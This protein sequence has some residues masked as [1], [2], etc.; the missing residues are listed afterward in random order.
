MKHQHRTRCCVAVGVIALGISGACQGRDVRIGQ[1]PTAPDDDTPGAGQNDQR[2][3]PK[4]GLDA[5]DAPASQSDVAQPR[6]IDLAVGV[7][8]VCALDAAG[9]IR[10]RGE[11]AISPPEGDYEYRQLTAGRGFAC[12]LDAQGRPTCW[13]ANSG[14]RAIGRSG[15]LFK[16]LSAGGHACGVLDGGQVY[17]RTS[18]MFGDEGAD[19][20]AKAPHGKFVQVSAGAAH[21][22]GVLRDGR[23]KCWGRNWDGVARAPSGKFKMVSAGGFISC[24]VRLSGELSC[25]GPK[26]ARVVPKGKFQSVSAGLWHACGLRQDGTATCWGPKNLNVGS[27][28]IKHLDTPTGRFTRLSSGPK[29]ACALTAEGRITCWGEALHGKWADL[30][31]GARP[32]CGRWTTWV[33]LGDANP[34]SWS[35]SSKEFCEKQRRDWIAAGAEEATPCRCSDDQ[36][37]AWFQ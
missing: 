26:W 32:G 31:E 25:W 9:R 23:A 15:K 24:G 20:E 14:S 34:S 2:V 19:G 5:A 12:A 1:R 6:F 3:K 17:C 4:S 11:N 29:S 35:V 21:T 16:Q 18:Y 10:C 7:G 27:D 30:K 28:Y 33:T 22:C 8:F 37:D 13:G 36:M